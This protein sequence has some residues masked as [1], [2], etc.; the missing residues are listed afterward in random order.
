VDLSFLE[1]YLNV[2]FR[3]LD[4]VLYGI[5]EKISEQNFDIHAMRE[6]FAWGDVPPNCFVR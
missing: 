5:I 4:G 6:D 1:L 3:W 2:D